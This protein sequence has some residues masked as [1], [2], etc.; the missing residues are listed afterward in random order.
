MFTNRWK[1]DFEVPLGNE[2][3]MWVEGLLGLT[4]KKELS[5]INFKP[6]NVLVKL[7]C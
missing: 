3:E 4:C 7:W 1:D 5:G 6:V 2:H